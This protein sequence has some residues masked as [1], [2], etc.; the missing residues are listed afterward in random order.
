MSLPVDR[1]QTATMSSLSAKLLQEPTVPSL[2]HVDDHLNTFRKGVYQ[3]TDGVWIA[4]G[5]ALANSICVETQTGLVIIDVLEDVGAAREVCREFKRL[6]SNKP[7]KAVIFTHAH[8]DHVAGIK[9]FVENEPEEPVIYLHEECPDH[10]L[11]NVMFKYG[12]GARSVRQ[13]GSLLCH[14]VPCAKDKNWYK[15]AGIGAELNV[16]DVIDESGRVTKEFEH[17]AAN[18]ASFRTF[19]ERHSFFQDGVEFEMVAAFGE[20]DNQIL[21]H[22]PSK[23][24]LLPGDNIC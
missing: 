7:I 12:I 24:L 19:N 18:P 5:Y 2:K 3:I 8:F 14:Q 17:S 6:T 16:M 22:V 15:N 4:I 10:E 11:R 1:V 23:S 13:F 20:T 9:G 21:I